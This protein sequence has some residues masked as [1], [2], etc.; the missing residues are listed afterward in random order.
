MDQ[1]LGIASHQASEGC[2]GQS[3]C[4]PSSQIS[5]TFIRSAAVSSPPLT[6]RHPVPVRNLY[7]NETG[8]PVLRAR[9]C[10]RRKHATMPTGDR[11]DIESFQMNTLNR[12]PI[13]AY[14][15]KT[16][17]FSVLQEVRLSSIGL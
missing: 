1:C 9:H 3:C 10:S 6:D 12:G 7:V 16:C 8:K 5:F 17:F 2:V 4:T 11:A 15:D 14:I 13:A